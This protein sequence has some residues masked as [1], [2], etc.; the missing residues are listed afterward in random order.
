MTDFKRSTHHSLR[1]NPNF[2]YTQKAPKGYDNNIVKFISIVQKL[3]SE[4]S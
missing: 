2:C 3:I 1:A 4:T